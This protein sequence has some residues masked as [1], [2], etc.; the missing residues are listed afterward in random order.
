MRRPTVLALA[1]LLVALLLAACGGDG[2]EDSGDSGAEPVAEGGGAGGYGGGSQQASGGQQQKPE[3][4]R[5]GTT[6]KLADSQFGPVL[7]DGDEQA[8]YSFDKET[9]KRSECYGQCAVEW[10]PVLTKGEP[11]AKGGVSQGKLGTTKRRDGSTQVTYNGHPLYY[12][13]DEAQGELRC[14]NVPG[15]G[16][17]WLALD[18]AGNPA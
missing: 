13:F 10:P 5:K 14:H 9:T 11:Q 4:E 18:Q 16:G 1:L 8:I 3:K 2:D 7:W 6:I 17:L 12:Y 15:F